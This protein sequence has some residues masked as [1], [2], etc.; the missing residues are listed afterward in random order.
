MEALVEVGTE[1]KALLCRSERKL[2]VSRVEGCSGSA[3]ERPDES[4]RVAQ[5]A[6]RLDATIEQLA[7]LGQLAAH[8]PQPAQSCDKDE[9]ELALPGRSRHR[10]C[11]GGVH[12]AVGVPPEI[13]LRTGQPGGRLQVAGELVV[14]KR[15]DDGRCLST[16]RL[17]SPR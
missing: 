14:R 1:V 12:L 10:Q 9:S 17:G 3:K 8:A 5:Q 2:D 15:I 13:E 16:V 6:R 11:A 7:G 4:V